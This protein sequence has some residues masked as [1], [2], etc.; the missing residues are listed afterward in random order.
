MKKTIKLWVALIA[1]FVLSGC[2]QNV[3]VTDSRAGSESVK[4][5]E[6]K[7]SGVA[8]VCN[9][10]PKELVESALGK[11]IPKAEKVD[12]GDPSCYYYTQYIDNYENSYS[13]EKKPGGPKIV[14]VYD[15]KDFAKDRISNEK[16]G[17][18]YTNDSSIGMDNFVV[19]NNVNKIWLVALS[20]G[21]ERYIRMKAFDDAVTG[22]ELIKVAKKFAEKIQNEK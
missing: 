2:G 19:R 22:E 17:S 12:I 16:S 5:E 4:K 1:I 10:F 18:K 14:V 6:T 13:G 3:D 11:T 8:D 9:Y 20:L 15:T 21:G 7:V